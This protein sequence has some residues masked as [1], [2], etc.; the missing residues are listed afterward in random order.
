MK[1]KLPSWQVETVYVY[2]PS[3]LI[4]ISD[5]SK[6]GLVLWCPQI[7]QMFAE[8]NAPPDTEFV[9]GKHWLGPQEQLVFNITRRGT[10]T[11]NARKGK[12]NN[13]MHEWSLCWPRTHQNVEKPCQLENEL[14]F[15]SNYLGLS[16]GQQRCQSVALA[17]SFS[18]LHSPFSQA[19]LIIS[20]QDLLTLLMLADST[21][22]Q[23]LP[24]AETVG[25]SP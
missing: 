16:F 24:L 15:K 13:F 18:S 4:L 19:T 17:S 25:F 6:A 11:A 20:E 12:K 5:I 9:P 7:K 1:C 10:L 21:L 22:V 3:C 23:E 14:I 8:Q 2:H